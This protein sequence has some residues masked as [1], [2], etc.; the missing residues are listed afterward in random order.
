MG[1]VHVQCGREAEDEFREVWPTGGHLWRLDTTAAIFSG[2][3]KSRAQQ[4]RWCRADHLSSASG[5]SL[6]ALLP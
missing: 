2:K 1:S 4:P 3:E 5:S 6:S